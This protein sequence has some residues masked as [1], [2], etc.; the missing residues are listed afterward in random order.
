[1]FQEDADADA[2]HFLFLLQRLLT[3]SPVSGEL[4]LTR[5]KS[6]LGIQRWCCVI[7]YPLPKVFFDPYLAL[8][9]SDGDQSRKRTAFRRIVVIE[10]L[11]V[12]S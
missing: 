12:M 6:A 3:Q 4:I 7:G 5:W 8:G 9:Y 1:M 11:G 10:T 2:R